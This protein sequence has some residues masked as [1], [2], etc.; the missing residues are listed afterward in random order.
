MVRRGSLLCGLFWG[1]VASRGL[2]L[3]ENNV[4]SVLRSK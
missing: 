1:L 2:G 4:G 3:D